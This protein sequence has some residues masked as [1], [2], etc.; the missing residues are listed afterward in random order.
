M[1]GVADCL[2]TETDTMHWGTLCAVWLAAG[3]AMTQRQASGRSSWL[4]C[5]SPWVR[6]TFVGALM[7]T[8]QPML[9]RSNTAALAH[10]ARVCMCGTT[11]GEKFVVTSA[12]KELRVCTFDDA[13]NWWCG[14][15]VR[16]ADKS[17]AWRP[18]CSCLLQ[19]IV[20]TP[21]LRCPSFLPSLHQAPS[22]QQHGTQTAK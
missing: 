6:R 18:P 16:K 21:H 11:A 9:H 7:V 14:E 10:V 20:L 1:L 5:A 22:L 8:H 13:N 12:M 2:W 3:L 19:A 15:A 17:N 4:C